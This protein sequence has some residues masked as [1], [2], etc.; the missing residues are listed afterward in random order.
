MPLADFDW[1]LLNNPITIPILAVG[2]T[3][4]W[5]TVAALSDAVARVMCRRAD[6]E[7]KQDLV[8][9]GFSSDEIIRVT[10]AGREPAGERSYVTA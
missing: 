7:L 3:F 10:E 8:A 9:R 4:V 1:S 5:L 6:V 2:G